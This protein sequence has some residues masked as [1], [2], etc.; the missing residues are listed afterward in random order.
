MPRCVRTRVRESAGHAAVVRPRRGRCPGHRAAGPDC[1]GR[2][3][4][5]GPRARAERSA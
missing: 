1:G 2:R 5:P 3:H 4:R